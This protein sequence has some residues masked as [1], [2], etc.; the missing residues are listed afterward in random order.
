MEHARDRF[1]VSPDRRRC[2][3]GERLMLRTATATQRRA[4]ARA[5]RVELP[6]SAAQ[7]ESFAALA[8]LGDAVAVLDRLAKQVRWTS[9]AWLA[10]LP[11]L[12]SGT[13]LAALETALPGLQ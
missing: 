4:P 10:L 1:V 6:I 13:T 2:C 9:P 11:D 3:R 7:N 8:Q 5:A 12:G